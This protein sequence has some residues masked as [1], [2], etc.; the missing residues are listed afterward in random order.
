MYEPF[1]LKMID[2]NEV[3]YIAFDKDLYQNFVIDI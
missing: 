3:N 1:S 2:L